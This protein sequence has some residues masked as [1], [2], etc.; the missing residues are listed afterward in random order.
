M[1]IS[2]KKERKRTQRSFYKVKKEHSV[3]FSIYIYL[4]ISIYIYI[5]I[6]IYVYLYIYL[7]ISMYI[8]IYILKKERNVLRSFAKER[9]VLAFFYVLCKRTLRSLHSFTFF[10]KVHCVLCI[11]LCSLQKNVAF[12]AFFYVLCK[13]RLH[14]LRSFTFLRKERKRTHRSFGSHKSPKT[15]KKNV[16]EWNV[17]FKERKR[18]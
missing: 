17:L 14:S 5:Y 3:P 6:S 11:L 15:R 8:Y 10:A 13:R 16:K 9:N 7:Y 12:F 4:Y 2:Q 1:Q 18:T